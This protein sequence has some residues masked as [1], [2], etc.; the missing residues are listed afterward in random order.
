MQVSHSPTS[1]ATQAFFARLKLASASKVASA[2]ILASCATQP[3]VHAH[4]FG[5]EFL[6][7]Y[8][9]QH[10]EAVSKS[11]YFVVDA[12][13]TG[14]TPYSKP[15]S[16][17]G[18][19]KIGPVWTL[20]AFKKEHPTWALDCRVRM[21]VWSVQL[22]DGSRLAWD[23]D[24]LSKSA[25]RH[26]L[27]D[28]IHE[29]VVIGHNIGFDFT[30]AVHLAGRD[31]APAL[32]LDTMLVARCIKPASVYGVH[33]KAT[34]GHEGAMALVGKGNASV[35]LAA[36]AVGAGMDTPDKS[37]QHPRNWAVSPLTSGHHAY[38]LGDI[39]A[40]LQLLLHWGRATTLDVAIKN[41]RA[42]D[43]QLG[44]AYFDVYS[45]VPMALAKISDTGMP[46]HLPTLANVQ[47]DRRARMPALIATVIETMPTCA[48][49]LALMA[50][51]EKDAAAMQ[52]AFEAAYGVDTVE[53]GCNEPAMGAFVKVLDSSSPSTPALL[54]RVI[55]CYAE[56]HGCTL[57]ETEEGQPVIN[58]KAA[59]MRGAAALP[60]WVAWSELQSAKKILALCDEY[61]GI[62]GM[63]EPGADFRQL[64]PLMSARTATGR[65]AGQTPNTMNLPNA[66]AM[67][68]G[69][70]PFLTDEERDAAWA[71]LQF[72][73]IIRA[74]EGHVLVSADYGQIE[75]RIAAA[76][77]LRAIEDAKKV[78]AGEVSIGNAKGWFVDALKRGADTSIALDISGGEDSGFEGFRDRIAHVWRRLVTA[79]ARPMAD[80]FKSGLDPH[81]LTGI[82]LAQMQGLIDL[83]GAHPIDFLRAQ[84]KAQ[85]KALNGRF[86][87]QRQMAKAPNFGLLY[88]QQAA[89]LYA[90][91]VLNYGLT[92]SMDE[93]A[94]TRT[95]WFD[96]Y[97]EIE[98]LQLWHQLVLMPSKRE[99]EPLYRKNP[100]SMKLGVE[101][102]RIGASA[103]LRGR[104]V[105]AT[106]AREILNYA[107]QGSGADI[108]L[109]ATV[110]L[111]QEAFDCVINLIHDQ[112][113][114]I[115]PVER[116]EAVKAEL[117]RAMSAAADRVLAPWGIPSEADAESMPFWRKE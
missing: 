99:A 32:V 117:E 49:V 66:S 78:L 90:L 24:A 33:H 58:A 26:L 115:V 17:G 16:V 15:I 81:L 62:S 4:T 61:I 3:I 42:M 19:A 44:G 102:V 88:G 9:T 10:R 109:E 53:A 89:G 6:L 87:A 22:S 55:A 71:E 37:W 83:G 21:R 107:D 50:T 116:E 103:T 59:K 11:T 98:F 77:A 12:E 57:D 38:V 111:H 18:S 28:T 27:R 64:H 104:P 76:L 74:P 95:A 7:S 101:K 30:W 34:E 79:T 39:D 20:T 5:S 80:V 86:K 92:W 96:L 75:L 8:T 108:M 85:T 60:G 69:F 94:A 97:P 70:C 29:R 23:L 106:E 31:L 112:L 100:H 105:V 51:H 35:S 45:R 46:V 47:A 65:V 43:T 82:T 25:Q 73:A 48:E 56:M 67:P 72:R 1:V 68:A 84:D 110:N 13:T 54:K 93:A 2:A 52:A 36:L 63:D 91:G 41:L 113:Q 14:L 114:L 40:P